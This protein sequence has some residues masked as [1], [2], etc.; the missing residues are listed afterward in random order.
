MRLLSM[1]LAVLSG[2]LFLAQDLAAQLSASN[3]LGIA[4]Q[5]RTVGSHLGVKLTDVDSDRAK[6]LR[7]GEARGA[8]PGPSDDFTALERGAPYLASVDLS[9][10]EAR[11][12]S[13][14]GLRRYKYLGKNLGGQ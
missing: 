12:F 7:L 11:P 1:V 13:P 10:N 4:M 3:S 8:G 5:Y 9:L 14:S 2:I 6:V